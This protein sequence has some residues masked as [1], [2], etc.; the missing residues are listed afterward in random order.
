MAVDG[1]EER[2]DASA[3]ACL[4]IKASY[5]DGLLLLT[6]AFYKHVAVI[7]GIIVNC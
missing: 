3:S 7:D 5:R 4:Y 6:I 2:A 1:C